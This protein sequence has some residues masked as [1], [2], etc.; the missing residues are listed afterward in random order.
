MRSRASRKRIASPSRMR[1]VSSATRQRSASPSKATP[2]SQPVSAHQARDLLRHGRAAVDV[3]V[4]AVGLVV[5]RLDPRAGGLEQPPRPRR[6]G[7]VGGVDRDVEARERARRRQRAQQMLEV[8]L[9][10]RGVG[11]RSAL[12]L[13]CRVPELRAA[14]ASRRRS[15][16]WLHLKPSASNS[17]TPLSRHGLWL[18]EID[19]P[20]A[21]P[22]SRTSAATAG[23]GTTPALATSRA[24]PAA[25]PR[26]SQLCDLGRAVAGVAAEHDQRPGRSARATCGPTPNRRA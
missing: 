20:P 16:S 6:R 3:D 26:S 23:V 18:A 14:G 15:C 19:T 2:R 25:R 7:A 5:K 10:E 4:L 24:R 12:R 8:A 9:A 13:A 22:S 11:R 1:P 21:A 17:L